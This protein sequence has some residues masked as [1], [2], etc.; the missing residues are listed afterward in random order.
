MVLYVF[1]VAGTPY[2]KLGYTS[3]CPWGRV[4]DG[5][6][7]LVHPAGCCG[8]L[9]WDNLRLLTM[10]P[11]SLQDEAYVKAQVPP[12]RGEFWPREQLEALRAVMKALA[13]STGGCNDEN[14]ELP[15]PPKPE[16][17]APGRGVEKLECCGGSLIPCFGCGKHFKL[18]VRLLTHKR[19][20]CPATAGAKVACDRCG[21]SVIKRHLKRHQDQNKRCRDACE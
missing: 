15:L 1:E 16:S 6:W 3:A 18:Y 17:P 9:G 5:F 21:A 14:W 7:R 10:S 11:G 4:R 8:K 20:S 13:V 2:V 12:E 19:E